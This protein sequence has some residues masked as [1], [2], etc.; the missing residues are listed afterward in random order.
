MRQGDFLGQQEKVHLH[1]QGFLG[2]HD[3]IKADGGVCLHDLE[4]SCSQRAW[5]EQNMVGNADLADVVQ[6]RRL[7][8]EIN[9]G[10]AHHLTKPGML[11]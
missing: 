3:R 6:R 1:P 2:A 8:Q 5:L 7:E 9:V 10:I 11:L 4:F